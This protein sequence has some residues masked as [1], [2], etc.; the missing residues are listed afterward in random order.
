MGRNLLHSAAL[1]GRR[2]LH[3]FIGANRRCCDPLAAVLPHTRVD[4]FTRYSD[5][6]AR[7]IARRPG[8]LVAD[9]G[10]GHVAPYAAGLP[11]LGRTRIVGIDLSLQTME[12]NDALDEK[13]V[14]DVVA[15]GIPFPDAEVDIVT[16][17]SVLE[18]LSNVELLI[19]ETARVL[20]QGGYSIHLFSGGLSHVALINRMIP[21]KLARE[22]LYALH[23]T[24]RG[25]GGQPTVYDR[26][27]YRA[28][29]RMFE[30]NGF[31]QVD[32]Y[33][34]F[35]SD[36]FY[37]LVPLF[38][39]ESLYLVALQTLRVRSLAVSYLVLARRA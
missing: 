6:V 32:I 33:A 22:M 36:Y 13:R 15:E 38:L 35:G 7:T 1:V 8:Q 17:R 29:K 24:S 31:D 20:K 28:V 2:G 12:G 30:G 18:H 5:T 4:V 16:S 25:V 3:T 37:F 10:A 11:V 21:E 23:P 26:C 19:G 27:H 39:L 9:V 34:S 14:A